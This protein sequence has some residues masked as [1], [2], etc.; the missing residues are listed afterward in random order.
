MTSTEALKILRST[1]VEAK[2]N[3]IR[4]LLRHGLD[5]RFTQDVR[6]ALANTFMSGDHALEGLDELIMRSPF[7]EFIDIFY[8]L[9]A[10]EPANRQ[11]RAL[12]LLGIWFKSG[13]LDQKKLKSILSE[14]LASNDPW[15]RFLATL[16]LVR[17]FG[18]ERALW[19]KAASAIS[20]ADQEEWWRS[21]RPQVEEIL[22]ESEI[23]AINHALGELRSKPLAS[24]RPRK[25][26]QS[27]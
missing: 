21:I 2:I 13:L 8:R 7:P 17:Y 24:K 20:A 5:D 23:D 27:R 26:E 18:E 12:Q 3:L 6:V 15:V 1:S 11:G 25:T 16:K 9:V 4:Y 10:S 22:D 19:Q 14:C